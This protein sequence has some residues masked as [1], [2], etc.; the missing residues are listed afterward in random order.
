M[1]NNIRDGG[2]AARPAANSKGL[3]L[4]LYTSILKPADKTQDISDRLFRRWVYALCTYKD[5]GAVMPG[6]KALARCFGCTEQQ[7]QTTVNELVDAGLFDRNSDG[8][9]TPHDWDEM[10]FES[11]SAASRM[12][13]YRARKRAISSVTGDVTRYATSSVT[14]AA[15]ETETETETEEHP[16]TPSYFAD[17]AEPENAAAPDLSEIARRMFDRHPKGRKV[18]V[19][20]VGAA[21][22]ARVN[23]AV[24]P[25]QVAEGYERRHAGWCKSE[26][27][28]KRSGQFCPWLEGWLNSDKS[29]AEPPEAQSWL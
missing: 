29:D 2:R 6:M 25:L 7:A 11:D 13:N 27:W 16:P 5:N 12:R 1:S 22:I 8:T 21:L 18:S 26:D 14:V 10:Q 17:H 19:D 24:N 3:W 9:V 28:T 4:R 20:R 23:G 15:S